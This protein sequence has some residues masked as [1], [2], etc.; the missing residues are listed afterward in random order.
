MQN[1]ITHSN[2]FSHL[3]I[4]FARMMLR[5]A[6]SQDQKLF[7]ASALV[8]NHTREGHICLDLNEFDNPDF[9]A[10]K[11]GENVNFTFPSAHELIRAIS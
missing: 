10:H 11:F 1:I 2:T 9:L 7:L 3:D 4:H 6:D 8:S 5:L